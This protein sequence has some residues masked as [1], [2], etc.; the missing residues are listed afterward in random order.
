MAITANPYATNDEFSQELDAISKRLVGARANAEALAD[1]PGQLPESLVD[2]YTIQTASI[3]RW[4]RGIG[5][6]KV[7]MVPESYRNS[8]AAERLAG[9]IF[10]DSIFRIEAESKRTMQIFD[11]GFAAIEAE[12]VLEVAKTIEPTGRIYSDRELADLISSFA[13]A[14]ALGHGLSSTYVGVRVQSG[15]HGGGSKYVLITSR[16]PFLPY[17]ILCPALSIT[18]SKYLTGTIELVRIAP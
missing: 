6:W 1:F 18:F 12:F 3:A 13:F 15:L 7:G 14:G 8:L 10:D 16:L 2:A 4:S 5:G 17:K 11:G 9:P